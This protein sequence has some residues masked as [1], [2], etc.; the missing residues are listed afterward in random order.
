[1]SESSVSMNKLDEA[2]AGMWIHGRFL[3]VCWSIKEKNE[4]AIYTGLSEC[5]GVYK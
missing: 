5:G 3:F 4:Y 2:I 1:M